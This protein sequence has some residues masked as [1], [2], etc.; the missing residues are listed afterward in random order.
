MGSRVN[1]HKELLVETLQY[2]LSLAIN[3][4]YRKRILAALEE[5]RNTVEQRQPCD[6]VVSTLTEFSVFYRELLDKIV[7][8]EN[9]GWTIP[10]RGS[11]PSSE[12]MRM[13]RA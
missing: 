7:S 8:T 10:S 2:L 5:V 6:I 3:P 4:T 12:L 11:E 1:E 13:T 9:E